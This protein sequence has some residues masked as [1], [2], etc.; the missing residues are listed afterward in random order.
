[1]K[2]LEKKIWRQT[3]A[4]VISLLSFIFLYYGGVNKNQTLIY[5]GFIIF[6]ISV[7]GPVVLNILKGDGDNG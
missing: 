4:A 2:F 7:L 6:G 3:I 1:M 5:L